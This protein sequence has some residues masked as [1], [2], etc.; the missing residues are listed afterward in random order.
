[1]TLRTDGRGSVA[2]GRSL[3]EMVTG[4]AG[5]SGSGTRLLSISGDLRK[6]VGIVADI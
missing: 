1:M 5:K 6:K 2:G 3:G 4:M